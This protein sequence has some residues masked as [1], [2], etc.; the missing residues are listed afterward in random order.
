MRA[1][2]CAD[3]SW[4]AKYPFD[5]HSKEY[6]KSVA[7]DIDEYFSEDLIHVVERG[8][9]RA[10]SVTRGP[11]TSWSSDEA[12]AIAYF[13]AALIVRGTENR[14]LYYMFA[15]AESKRAYAIL[16]RDEPQ[17]VAILARHLGLPMDYSGG[18]YTM[19]LLEYMRLS[20]KFLSPHWKAYYHRV[21]G[22]VIFLDRRRAARLV[23]EASKDAVMRDLEGIEA[24]PE[25][26]R[27]YSRRLIEE[28]GEDVGG[29]EAG[30]ARVGPTRDVS[31]YPPCIRWMLENLP[32][33]IPHFAR[34][35]LVTFLGKMGY[36]IDEIVEVFS[37]VPDF[38][39]DKTR[40]Q[41][42]HIMGLRGGRK[43]YEVPSCKTLR[44]YNL[45]FPDKLCSRINHPLQYV[46]RVS[47]LEARRQEGD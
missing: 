15:D 34:F 24:V 4:A 36:S 46:A 31:K 3:A 26:I 32:A 23:S 35:T 13:I 28:V 9:E 12:E 16:S 39:P 33:G 21:E 11:L 2:W 43:V 44:S 27:E 6:L 42:E 38:K 29:S 10:L 8:F 18:S 40:Y 30:P 22:G 45:C 47:M 1:P 41:V 19:P 7:L 37:R 20:R 5:P 25:R 17:N 14:R